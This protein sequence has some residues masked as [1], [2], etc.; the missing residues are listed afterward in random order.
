MEVFHFRL[1][2]YDYDYDYDYLRI[3]GKVKATGRQTMK[4]KQIFRGKA[5]AKDSMCELPAPGSGAGIV[6]AGVVKGVCSL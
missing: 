4:E 3:E 5:G 2:Y 6:W 1:D